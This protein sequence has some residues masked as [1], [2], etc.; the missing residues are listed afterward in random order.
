MEGVRPCPRCK[1]EVEVVRMP[2]KKGQK[3]YRIQC[4]RCGYTVGR[5]LGFEE[6]TKQQAEER[7]KQYEEYISRKLGYA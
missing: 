5:G 1:G 7:I 4:M 6:E 3:T 2:D